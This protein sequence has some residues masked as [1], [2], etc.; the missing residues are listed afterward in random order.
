[1]SEHALTLLEWLS[2]CHCLAWPLQYTAAE[3]EGY[4]E[5]LA[6]EKNDKS[7]KEKLD[8]DLG[9]ERGFVMVQTGTSDWRSMRLL[10]LIMFHT[11]ELLEWEREAVHSQRVTAKSNKLQEYCNKFKVYSAVWY[12]P[13]NT[14]PGASLWIWKCSHPGACYWKHISITSL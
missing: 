6:R 5:P 14:C 8:R 1:M 2:L 4:A 7:Q 11:R 3:Q 9:A 10:R 13:M 12:P